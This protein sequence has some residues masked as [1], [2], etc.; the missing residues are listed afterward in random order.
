MIFSEPTPE[1][2]KEAL[3]AGYKYK[4][5]I[6]GCTIAYW[7]AIKISKGCNCK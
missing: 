1:Q 6:V 3:D 4:R 5:V 2:I 7:Q